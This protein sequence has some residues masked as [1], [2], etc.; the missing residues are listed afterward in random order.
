MVAV[1]RRWTTSWRPCLRSAKGLAGAGAGS[2]AEEG[3]PS[4]PAAEA[5]RALD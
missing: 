1:A 4:A 5:S 3:S 2:G